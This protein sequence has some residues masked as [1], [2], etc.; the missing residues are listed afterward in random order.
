MSNMGK[1]DDP[2]IIIMSSA[3][4]DNI[5]ASEWQ[6]LEQNSLYHNPF[7]HRWNLLP[8]LHH[9]TQS[10]DIYV[11]VLKKNNKLI[12]LFPVV[13]SHFYNA[14][15][16]LSMWSHDHCYL[17]DPLLLND[18][19]FLKII[20]RICKEF[21]ARWFE[22]ESHTPNLIPKKSRVYSS[23]FSR[24][25]ITNN[26]NISKYMDTCD[27]KTR[28]ENRRILKRINSDYKIRYVERQNVIPGISQYSDL[29]HRGWKGREG[30]SI[31]SNEQVKNYYFEMAHNQCA[32]DHVV[33][34]ELW[35]NDKLIAISI[36]FKSGDCWFD[37]KTCYDENFKKYYPGKIL[38][39]KNIL[40]LTGQSFSVIDSCTSSGNELINKLWPEQIT[41]QFSRVFLSNPASQF[42]RFIYLIKVLIHN[43]S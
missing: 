6:A 21:G 10:N 43:K 31:L 14:S 27:G 33:F 37:V 7:Y 38:E 1:V 34:H 25:A 26:T 39:L 18:M 11:V 32:A 40:S 12:G 20:N 24:A 29:E 8:A 42:W 19:D 17:T 15:K 2:E 41:F 4:A 13:L 28:R 5:D 36:R 3:D 22:F 16:Y 9:L 35:A 23:Q 30:G